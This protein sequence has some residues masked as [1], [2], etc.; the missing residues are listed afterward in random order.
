MRDGK[1]RR[2]CAPRNCVPVKACP[3]EA[4]RESRMKSRFLWLL[5]VFSMMI[6]IL[7]THKM[8]FT[9]ME[10]VKSTLG[11]SGSGIDNHHSIPREQYNSRGSGSTGQ[12]PSYGDEGNNQGS[13]GGGVN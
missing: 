13:G 10:N 12:Q 9:E 1:W 4:A 2:C 7:A 8:T 3:R 11:Y 5:L 6:C